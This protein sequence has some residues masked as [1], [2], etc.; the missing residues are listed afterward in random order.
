MLLQISLNPAVPKVSLISLPH[1]A[2]TGRP[3][4]GTLLTGQDALFG[5]EVRP[6]AGR[7]GE[8]NARRLRR[9]IVVFF[10]KT[11]AGY[12]TVGLWAKNKI[13]CNYINEL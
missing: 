11:T 12:E 8:R 7:Q 4:G 5:D 10:K 1:L 6:V 3:E 13:K 2:P 9:A